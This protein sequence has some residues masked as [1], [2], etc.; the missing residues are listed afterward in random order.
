M[1]KM[2][3]KVTNLKDISLDQLR[4]FEKNSTNKYGLTPLFST[5]AN[6]C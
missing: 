2:A 5:K 3:T 6:E 1:G 4:T